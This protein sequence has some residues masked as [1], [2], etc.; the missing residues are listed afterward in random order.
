MSIRRQQGFTLIELMVVVTVVG[1][2]MAVAIP[3]YN[4]QVRATR[5]ADA[6]ADLPLAGAELDD[7]HLVGL[8]DL[9]IDLLADVAVVVQCLERFNTVN[10]TYVASATPCARTNDFYTITISGLSASAFAVSAAPIA[11]GPQAGDR[12]GTFQINQAGSKTLTGQ[13]TGVTAA[14]CKWQ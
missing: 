10:R 12:C 2:L 14:D 5:R 11:S 3:A 13:K 1:I 6:Q 8:L 7:L 9:Q 4:E